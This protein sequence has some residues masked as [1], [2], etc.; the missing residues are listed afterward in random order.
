MK[1]WRWRTIAI[2]AAAVLTLGA[3]GGDDDEDASVTESGAAAEVSTDEP[4]A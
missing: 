2:G 3:C 1:S 4:A